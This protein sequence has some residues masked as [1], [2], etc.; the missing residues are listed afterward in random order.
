[1]PKFSKESKKKLA[2][3]DSRLQAVFFEV[4]K[5]FDCI[6]LCGHRTNKIQA[7]KYAAGLSKTPPGKSKHNLSPSMAVDAAPYYD[8]KP[9][10][11]W[12]N[13][14]RLLGQ[15]KR[16]E[17]AMVLPHLDE[18]LMWY[19]FAG[20]VQGMAQQL[21]LKVRWGGNWDSDTSFID[22]TFDDLCHF[23]LVEV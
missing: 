17:T 11:R 12:Y 6:I 23:E 7:A 9:H 14:Y 5:E 21:G 15:M 8:E 1:M 3:A 18:L 20:R 10:V 22:Q 13:K 2:T 19:H 4:I 16:G